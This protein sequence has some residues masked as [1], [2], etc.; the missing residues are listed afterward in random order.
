MDRLD[1][2]LYAERLTH[3]SERAADDLADARLHQSW[4]AFEVGVR[5]HLAPLDVARLSTIGLLTD[6][7]AAARAERSVNERSDDLIAIHHLQTIVERL[8]VEQAQVERGVTA[9]SR[10]PS[11]S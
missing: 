1:F 4:I 8:R 3:Y 10:P 11:S 9:S 6:Q 7:H 2:E 5:R